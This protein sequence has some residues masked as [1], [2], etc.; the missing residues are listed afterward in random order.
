MCA[1]RCGG[2]Q[3]YVHAGARD[4]GVCACRCVWEC[5]HAIVWGCR[6]M[7]ADMGECCIQV[8]VVRA[9]RRCKSVCILVC[10]KC[11]IAGVWECECVHADGACV[12]VGVCACSRCVGRNMCMQIGSV[13]MQVCVGE[14]VHAGVWVCGNVHADGG[15]QE[16]AGV[17]MQVCREC[18]RAGVGVQVCA[19]AVVGGA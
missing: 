2:V 8:W 1:C 5:M 12:G 4:V 13:C 6:S 9:G 11:V 7:H 19:H 14:C 10:E 3:E 15:V 17:C 18:V 16:C